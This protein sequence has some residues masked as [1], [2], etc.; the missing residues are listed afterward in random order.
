[1]LILPGVAGVAIAG[2]D[3][4]V[5]A[6]ITDA[7]GA[8]TGSEEG[9]NPSMAGGISA[10]DISLSAAAIISVEVIVVMADVMEVSAVIAAMA[11][12]TS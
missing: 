2:E 8:M 1:M 3:T 9:I 4:E 11:D 7:M 6:E 12:A 10:A 5:M